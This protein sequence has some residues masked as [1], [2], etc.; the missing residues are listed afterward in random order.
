MRSDLQKLGDMMFA[1]GKDLFPRGFLKDVYVWDSGEL[2]WAWVMDPDKL[3]RLISLESGDVHLP[4]CGAPVT[5]ALKSVGVDYD[6]FDYERDWLNP[7]TFLSHM[8][9]SM[10]SVPEFAES[11]DSFHATF[12]PE[13]GYPWPHDYYSAKKRRVLDGSER[14]S[15]LLPENVVD[16]SHHIDSPGVSFCDLIDPLK[17][18]EMDA[19]VAGFGRNDYLIVTHAMG[20]MDNVTRSGSWEENAKAINECGGLLFPSLAVGAVPATNFGPFVMVADAGVVLQS[21]KPYHKAQ[22]RIPSYVYDTDVWSETTGTFFKEAAVSAFEQLTGRSDWMTWFDLNVWSLGAP[23]APELHGPGIANRLDRVAQL[24]REV[25]ERASVY[26]RDLTPDDYHEMRE[27]VLLTKARYPYL[28]AKA[29]G[30]MPMSTFPMAVAP[31]QAA[32]GFRGFLDEVGFAG[33]LVT[34]ELPDE[35]SEVM[36]PEWR[37][38]GMDFD[39]RLAIQAW[40]NLEYGWH[41]ADAIR[42]AGRELEL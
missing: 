22:K 26:R 31:A 15:W 13:P 10:W 41:V 24:K 37:P 40:A 39:R 12:I 14:P 29:N 34:V 25:R 5:R 35:V 4:F 30:V 2:S 7:E 21:L 33:R 36:D 19:E 9:N 23:Q 6:A 20:S 16:P 3:R 28:E 8:A 1:V 17:D 11:T 27:R 32:D 42:E 38:A 18:Y